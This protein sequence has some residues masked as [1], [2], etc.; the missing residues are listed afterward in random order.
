MPK[1]T[2][3]NFVPTTIEEANSMS[4]VYADS[5]AFGM[6]SCCLQVTMQATCISESR[7][8]YDQL[9]PLTPILLALTAA[10]PFLRGWIC[11]DDARWGQISQSVDD[12]TASER[13]A[14]GREGDTR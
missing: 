14:D 1:H 12:R 4:H 13:A 5:M 9:A 7:F 11:D 8:L 6:G 2:E 10:T 3:D